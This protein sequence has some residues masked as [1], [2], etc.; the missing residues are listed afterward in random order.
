M[1]HAGKSLKGEDVVIIMEALQVLNKHLPVRIQ[2]GNGGKFIS[3][4][5]IN[6]RMS[7]VSRWTSPAPEN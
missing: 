3:K 2:V 4:N 5:Q 6:G 1:S 7:Q